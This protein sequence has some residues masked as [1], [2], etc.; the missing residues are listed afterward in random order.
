MIAAMGKQ[1]TRNVLIIHAHP[2]AGEGHFCDALVEAYRTG[3]SEAGHALE[4]LVLAGLDFPLLKS[5]AE[6]SGE[7]DSVDIRRAQEAIRQ[8][9]HLAFIHPLWM[10]SMPALL[11]AFLE[12]TLRPDFAF[13]QAARQGF[14]QRMLSGKSARVIITMG[15]PALAYRWFYRAHGY[16]FFKRNI[17]NF[18]GISPVRASF[19]GRMGALE[20]AQRE[21]WLERITAFGRQAR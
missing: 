2:D 12:Q 21:R 1:S 13:D 16:R 6:W 3:A 4:T 18:S 11:K 7:P 14:G 20:P 10:G 9:D 15:M 19:I 8:A 17:L 5:E